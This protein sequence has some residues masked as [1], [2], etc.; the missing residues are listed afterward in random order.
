MSSKKAEARD[1]VKAMREEQ[2]RS[3]RKRERMLRFG[4]AGA[5]IAAVAIIAVAV[6]ASRGNDDGPVALPDTVSEEGDGITFGQAD[7]PVELDVWLDFLCPYCKE[8]EDQNGVTIDELVA[9][10]DAKVTYH[11]VTFTGRNYSTRANNAFA[12]AVDQGEGEAYFKALFVSPQQWTDNALV[13]LGEPVGLGGEFESCVRE[14]TYNDWSGSV[15]DTA[16]ANGDISGTPTV[17]VNGEPL[18]SASWTPDAI[19][20]AVETAAAGG[21]VAPT[22]GATGE[23]TPTA[24]ATS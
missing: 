5:V 16:T 23:A 15:T 24:P 21:S 3:E 13:D 7:A 18:D 17:H 20:A 22:E 6:T 12:C 9:S 14:D 4:I 2:A 19:R 1:R 8:F 10:G 11:S